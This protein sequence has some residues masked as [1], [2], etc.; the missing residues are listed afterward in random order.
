[1]K[2]PLAYRNG[3]FVP[4]SRAGLSLHDAGFVQGATI[5]DLVRTFHQEPFRLGDHLTRFA[6]SCQLARIPLLEGRDS[7]EEVARELIVRNRQLLAPGKELG[8]VLF[9]TPGPIGWYLGDDAEGPPTIGMHTFPLPVA[10]YRHLLEYGATLLI[11]SIRH[12]P[13]ESIDRR[14]KHRSRLFWRV[15]DLEVRQR[16]PQAGALLLDDAGCVTETAAANF[17][18]V[19]RGTVLSPRAGRV[20]PGISLQVLREL[21]GDLGVP[22]EECDLRLEDCLEA[23]E[24]LLTC[25]T[26]CLAPVA[27][28][29]DR[30]YPVERP[31]FERFLGLWSQ[32][33]GVDIRAQILDR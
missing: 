27:R 26:F 31:L 6:E 10:R 3:E 8:L 13:A 15:A 24:A 1:M 14:I 12:L 9:A 33:V 7:L 11:P 30:T 25:T 2:E 20:L 19:R 18:V 32:R 22:F 23:D 5:T 4:V 16:D 21:C 29:E 17:L 28:L